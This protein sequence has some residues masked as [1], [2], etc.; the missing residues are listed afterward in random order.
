MNQEIIAVVASTPLGVIS[1]ESGELPWLIHGDL[2][3]FKTVTMSQV[4]ICGSKTYDSLGA[5]PLAGRRFAVLTSKTYPE[6]ENT[7][8]HKSVEELLEYYK[9]EEKLMVIGG[10]EVY[11]SMLDM[12]TSVCL[13]TVYKD[14]ENPGAYFPI[15][16]LLDNF[17]AIGQSERKEEAGTAYRFSMWARKDMVDIYADV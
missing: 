10:G 8:F 2:R 13:T 12:C 14:V 1:T 3:H 11:S 6:A 16:Q 5:R 9:D 15:Q 17:A 4:C 7:T